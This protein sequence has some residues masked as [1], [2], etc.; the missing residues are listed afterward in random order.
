MNDAAWFPK[1]ND[2]DLDSKS[3]MMIGHL[4]IHVA[5]T[6]KNVKVIVDVKVVFVVNMVIVVKKNLMVFF[7]GVQPYT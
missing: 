2:K 4:W 6:F 1:A 5:S 7:N 3:C